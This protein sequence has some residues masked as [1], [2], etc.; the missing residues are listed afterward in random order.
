MVMSAIWILL[1]A[2]VVSLVLTAIVLSCLALGARRS[3][4]NRR[5]P[6]GQAM[7][8]R[9]VAAQAPRWLH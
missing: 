2:A 8:R 5:T 4:K 6:R 3:R 1:C 9:I 7:Q